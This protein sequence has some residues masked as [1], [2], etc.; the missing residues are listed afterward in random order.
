MDCKAKPVG[1]PPNERAGTALKAAALRLV[2]E[3]GYSNVS[4]ADI[5]SAAG[6]ARQTLYNRWNTKADLILDAVFEETGRYAAEPP[7]DDGA[8]SRTRLETFLVQVFTHLAEDGATMRALIAAA[9]GDETFRAAWYERFAYPRELMVTDILR[10]AQEQGE[11]AKDRDP[12]LL[13]A[14]VHGAFWY[15]LLNGQ[16]VDADLARAIVAEIFERQT[17]LLPDR[18]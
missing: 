17:P 6:V 3:K 14:F 1:R 16:P 13:S 12:E 5:A 18:T 8:S 2:R 10:E 11:L 9:Q 15:R 4:I 7:E